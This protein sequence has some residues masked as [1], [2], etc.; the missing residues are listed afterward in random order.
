MQAD[1]IDFSALRK[2]NDGFC[3]VVVLIDVFSKYIYVECVKNKTSQCMIR[4]FSELL[5]RSGYFRLLQTDRGSEYTN[6]AFQ[7]WLKKQKIHFFHS[8]NYE[9]KCSI[10]ER[11]ISTLKERLWRYFTYTNTRRY[12]DVIQAIVHSYIH[13]IHSSIKCKPAEVTNDNQER[14]WQTLYGD[15]QARKPKLN[16]GDTVRLATTRATFQKGYLPK[17]TEE[18]FVLA[19][20]LSGDPPY[21]KIRD[22]NSEILEGTFY[23]SEL[24]KI[25][26]SDDT[27]QI[28]RIV[29]TRTKRKERQYLI[30][31][32]EYPESF[33]SWVRERDIVR[34]A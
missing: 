13:T 31:W 20:A 25:N 32:Y 26:K 7:A 9:I 17:W 34:Y 19:Q 28:E 24:Q 16:V 22:L 5:Q 1:L 30:K 29:K 12:V 33:N 3:Y 14:V 2:Y 11:C 23:D 4:A 8:H 27:S 18:L 15:I 6:R 10:V 21:Y